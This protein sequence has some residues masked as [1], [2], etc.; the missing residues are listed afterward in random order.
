MILKKL[1]AECREFG[2]TDIHI[3]SNRVVVCRSADNFIKM[4][5]RF[6]PHMT[7]EKIKEIILKEVILNREEYE[8]IRDFREGMINIDTT[9]HFSDEN[10]RINIYSDFQG[11]NVAVRVLPTNIPSMVDLRLPPIVQKFTSL[12]HGL[13]VIS[14]PTGSGKTT[15]IASMLQ[16][17]ARKAAKHIVTIEEPIEYKLRP[18]RAIV[19]Q[20]EVGLHVGSFAEGLREALRQDPDVILVGELRDA[21]TITTALQ[22]AETGHLVFTTLHAASTSEAIDRFSQFFPAERNHEIRIQLANCL[23]AVV[24]QKLFPLANQNSHK[25][26]AAFEVMINTDA[27]K[28]VIRSGK[29][30]HLKDYMNLNEGMFTMESS[31][32]GLKNKCLI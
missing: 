18:E 7:T 23:R 26:V 6:I 15:T 14:G 5:A 12:E 10:I 27:I 20:R 30:F 32:K 29:T 13:V 17:I 22:A 2:G 24:A 25:Q 3:K 31:I 9:C 28:A 11:L 16:D 1:I 4:G 21:D 19:T 8:R